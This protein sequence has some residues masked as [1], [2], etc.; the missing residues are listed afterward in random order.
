MSRHR[1]AGMLP[2]FVGSGSVAN[3][4]DRRSADTGSGLA[5]NEV[6]D[7]RLLPAALCCWVA[8]IVVVICGW[9]V[10]VALAIALVLLAI[11]SW[12]LLLRAMA[13][14]SDRIRAVLSVLA[15]AV[16]LAAGFS[17]AAAWRE[18]QVSAHPLR[19]M[20]DGASARVVAT[21]VSDP[22]PVRGRSFDGERR[23]LVPAELREFERGDVTVRAG[24]SVVILATGPAWAQLIPGGPIEFRARPSEPMRADLTVAALRPIDEPRAAGAVPWWQRAAAALR[25]DLAAASQQALAPDAAGLLP[26]LVVGDTSSVSE[27]LRDDFAAA[28]LQHLTVVSGANFTVVLTAVLFLARLATLGP[29]LSAILAAAAL[30]MFVVVARPDPSVLRA[31]AMGAVTVL[32]LVT[33]RRKQ[34]LPALCGAVIGMLA[35]WPEL[36]VQAGFALS[37]LATG[38]LLLLA[39]SWADWLRAH[40]WWRFPAELVAVSAAAFVVT[41]PIVIALSGKLSLVA[42]I[43]NVLVTPVIA[44][45]TVLGALA[46]VLACGWVPLA[47]P[48]LSCAAPMLWWLLSVAKY[49]AA[50]PGATVTVPGGAGGAMIA[51]LVVAVGIWALRSAVFRAL[52]GSVLLGIA[53][54]AI[55]LRLWHPGWPPQDWAVVACD[56]GQ[57]DGVVLAAGEHSAV[58][59]DTGPGPRRIRTCLDRLGVERVELLA[60]THMHADHIGGLDGVLAGRTVTAV[61]VAPNE[62]PARPVAGHGSRT[63]RG[64]REPSGNA[65]ETVADL[66]PQQVATKLGQAGVPVRELG[67][68]DRLRAGKVDLEVL[69]PE[70]VEAVP[71]ELPVEEANERSLV[72]SA[73]TA[74]GRVLITGDSEASVQQRLLRTPAALRADIL[75]VPHHGSR[76]TTTQF[77]SAVHP[78]LAMV[79]VGSGNTF[80]HPHPD[81]LADLA[82]LGSTVVRTDQHGDISVVPGAGGPAIRTTR[83]F[84]A[85]RHRFRG[86]RRQFVG[87]LPRSPPTR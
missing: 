60:L 69:A 25:G 27:Q 12:L 21:P 33:G 54:V 32:A 80:G 3:V 79:S 4:D 84:H 29:L 68:G 78:R 7:A 70:A 76:T 24:G 50:I 74:A 28:G 45:I 87:R 61:A 75:V 56:V 64:V 48:V 47:L 46:A 49:C 42:V 38:A 77:L 73:T 72:L 40:R 18:H 39:P 65:A 55:P 1:V 53:T 43:A 26:A 36:A 6:L 57:G 19:G 86:Y 17:V 67:T 83:P 30:V 85:Q 59:V 44:A 23:W 51:A 58:V 34:A 20:P 41:T 66:G 14:N 15:A 8:T 13:H 82:A 63:E 2:R 10:G 62:L 16:V 22:K 37:V 52:A 35:L 31:G 11:G 81:V 71:G 5:G 9:R